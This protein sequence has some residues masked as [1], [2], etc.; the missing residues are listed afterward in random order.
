M[1]TIHGLFMAFSAPFTGRLLD[2]FGRKPILHFSLKLCGISGTSGFFW[3]PF[4][5]FYLAEQF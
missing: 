1:S 4:I 5:S 2:D 3:I